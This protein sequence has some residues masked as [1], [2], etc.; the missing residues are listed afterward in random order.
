MLKQHTR[1][2]ILELRRKGQGIRAIARALQV[3][4][5]AV[6]A[7]IAAGTDE[8]PRIERD[9]KADPWREQ[10]LDLWVR[11][12]GHRGRVHEELTKLG[13]DVAYS[14]LTAWLKRQGLGETPRPPALNAPSIW[15]AAVAAPNM[16]PGGKAGPVSRA[17][18][19]DAARGAD[20]PGASALV[21]REL[22]AR[23][24]QRAWPG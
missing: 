10:V 12:E 1:T 16:K 6:K 15:Y 3:S 13:A 24:A 8:A 23:A 4:R 14:T 22:A 5:T 7:V 18:A 17:A 20:V 19:R 11:C 2:A 9:E 21:T